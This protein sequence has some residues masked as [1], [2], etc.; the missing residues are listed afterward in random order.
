MTSGGARARSG[1]PPDPNAL[2]RD[3]PSDAAGW[4]SLPAAGRA[5]DAPA[6]PLSRPTRRELELWAREWR[7]PQAIMWE[8]LGLENEVAVYVRT[9]VAGEKP[10]A[11][12]ATRTLLIR[13]QEA[14]GISL[15]GLA[16]NRWRIEGGTVATPA[17]PAKAA[18]SG[19]SAKE[20]LSGRGLGVIDGGA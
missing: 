2:R 5:G 15:P 14:L 16:R 17:P 6:W 4:V 13:Q 19:P 12:A 10:R 9:L 3:R 7:R 1:P 8:Q 18:S 20:R 11:T